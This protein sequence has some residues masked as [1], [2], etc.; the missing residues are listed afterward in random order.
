[1]E[2]LKLKHNIQTI[3][4]PSKIRIFNDEEYQKS[5]AV[6]QE[7]LSSCS[8]IFGVKEMPTSFFEPGKVYAFFSHTIKGQ[9]YNMPML[10]RLMSLGCY[11]IDYEKIVDENGRRLLFFGRYAGLAGMIDSLWALGKRL[12]WEGIV[13]PFSSLQQ[14]FR[15]HSLEE[16]KEAVTVVGEKI[17]KKGIPVSLTPLVCGFAGYGHVSKGAQ[18][19][20][21]LLPHKQIKPG[22]LFSL[23]KQK[24]NSED[25]LYKVVFREEDMVAPVSRESNFELQ[26]YYDHPEKYTS[27][28][29]AY[30]P[31]MTLL[32]NA[33]FWTPRYPRL[34]TKKGLK[35]LFE[36]EQS[37]RLRLIGDI[38][39][40]IE[41]A[42]ECTVRATQPDNPVFIYNP[43]KNQVTDGYKGTGVVVLAVD[44]LPCELPRSS[45]LDFGNTLTKLIPDILKADFSTDFA[46][47]RLSPRIKN[48]VILY[49]GKLTPQYEYLEKYL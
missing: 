6:V 27:K 4:Q 10:K 11:L 9:Q 29:E 21:D 43:L 40:D 14:T 8:I 1:M 17:K 30:L 47:C 23:F 31:Y 33:I 18:E 25:Y 44:N 20:F 34:I 16:A 22:E 49:K 15:Y 5:G 26:D 28:F 45:S 38:T 13:N 41:G 7:D 32:I 19:I 46:H 3:V 37:P 36:K 2:E 48:S 42:I 35:N 12:E 24:E 39:C